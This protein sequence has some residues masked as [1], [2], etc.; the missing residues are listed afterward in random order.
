MSY[1]TTG[2]ERMGCL[3]TIYEIFYDEDYDAINCIDVNMYS[4]HAELRYNSVFDYNTDTIRDA[5]R[6]VAHA[7]P[8]GVWPTNEARTKCVDTGIVTI[9][10]QSRPMTIHSRMAPFRLFTEQNNSLY[11]F[12]E[13]KQYGVLPA[14]MAAHCFHYYSWSTSDADKWCKQSG[15]H[16]SMFPE[17]MP[18]NGGMRCA[19]TARRVVALYPKYRSLFSDTSECM[20]TTYVIPVLNGIVERKLSTA[21]WQA[22]PGRWDD[23]L[24]DPNVDMKATVDLFKLWHDTIINVCE[25]V[26][27]ESR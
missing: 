17:L 6:E 7:L 19:Y 4:H 24:V 9:Q 18:T 25:D 26:K 1:Q 5:V 2:P 23:Q 21:L 12:Q 20:S 27:N 16:Q 3:A 22:F 15:W 11:F 10:R 14:W 8:Y 13:A